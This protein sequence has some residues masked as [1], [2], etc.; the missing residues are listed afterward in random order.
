MLLMTCMSH[1]SAV[2]ADARTTGRLGSWASVTLVRGVGI[3]VDTEGVDTQ[4]VTS[5]LLGLIVFK[6]IVFKSNHQYHTCEQR[7]DKA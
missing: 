4:V 7:T 3:E 6:L 5:W 2:D 1:A